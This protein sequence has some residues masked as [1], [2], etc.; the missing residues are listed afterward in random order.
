MA[1]NY[2]TSFKSLN[3]T[4]AAQAGIYFGTK[5]VFKAI[6]IH[7][8]NSPDK[9][10]GFEGAIRTLISPSSGVSAHFVAT[11]D[12]RKVA[13]LVNPKDISW[14][15]KQ[16]N[17]FTISIECDPSCRDD[18]YDVVAE[19]IADIRAQYGNL[20]LVKHSDYVATRCPGDWDLTRLEGVVKTKK[21]NGVYGQT[22]N[23]T[24]TGEIMITE[25]ALQ[26]LWRQ[27]YGEDAPKDAI[28]AY[29]GRFTF[30]RVYQD[31]VGSDKYKEK[32]ALAKAGKLD[33][34]QFAD[35]NIRTASGKAYPGAITQGAKTEL[36]QARD[37]INGL[38]SRS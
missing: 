18:D 24:Q 12:G 15:T 34:S 31:V 23:I 2:V 17:P 6:A 7:W 14:A 4:P 19:L 16:A 32:I 27:K 28:D 35:Y 36:E 11:G 22:K 3:F 25:L 29:V 21:S 13:N 26:V 9:N 5:R 10:P 20:P 37:A 33:M 38:L 8:W 30:D 1:Y